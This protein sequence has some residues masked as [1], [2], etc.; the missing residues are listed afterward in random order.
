MGWGSGVGSPGPSGAGLCPA[1]P[2]TP[3]ARPRA[4]AG[5][6][7]V[8]PG[9]GGFILPRRRVSPRPS[10]HRRS[11]L[12]ELH[13]RLG[14][15]HSQVGGQG[16]GAAG[17]WEGLP[18]RGVGLGGAEAPGGQ[19]RAGKSEG[20]AAPPRAPR[21]RRHRAPQHTDRGFAEPAGVHGRG[22]PRGRGG[23]CGGTGHPRGF[24]GAG[25]PAWRKSGSGR[26]PGALC[27]EG[28]PRPRAGGAAREADPAAAPRRGQRGIRA[29]AGLP[30]AETA[31]GGGGGRANPIQQPAPSQT[32]RPRAW[33][34][35]PRLPAAGRAGWGA[36]DLEGER[37]QAGMGYRSHRAR[38]P[39]PPRGP[40]ATPAA[41]R[42][43]RRLPGGGHCSAR[44]RG[45]GGPGGELGHRRRPQ[46]PGR[47]LSQ[48]P[49]AGPLGPGAGALGGG[50]GRRGVARRTGGSV[51]SRRQ[52]G[53][54]Q[55]DTCAYVRLRARPRASACESGGEGSPPNRGAWAA[56][57]CG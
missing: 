12:R 41:P 21:R 5:R 34:C 7:G 56:R 1:P 49:P 22:R 10:R 40:G 30:P 57:V 8:R 53:R 38:L 17:R 18:G 15:S 39:S 43:R 35:P 27:P 44:P 48:R 9:V 50:S 45:G 28:R 4:P 26:R 42:S 47:P 6:A 29:A 13:P 23:L 52:P 46:A 16:R 11:R 31:G 24:Q 2:R 32:S 37:G 20:V 54:G 36:G 19:P 33:H 55:T 14:R 3:G 51:R 25:K